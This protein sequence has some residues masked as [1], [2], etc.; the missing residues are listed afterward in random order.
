MDE[1]VAHT[2]AKDLAQVEL[3][4]VRIATRAL[5]KLQVSVT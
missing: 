5:Y 4:L 3:V 2:P 1:A